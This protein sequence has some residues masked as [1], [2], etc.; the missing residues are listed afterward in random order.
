MDSLTRNFSY[1]PFVFFAG[2]RICV[3]ISPASVAKGFKA[4][5]VKKELNAT[6][7]SPFG[8]ASLASAFSVTSAEALS[9]Q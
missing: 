2:M 7:R 6:T 8:P 4:S 9:L 3:K 5:P 1:A